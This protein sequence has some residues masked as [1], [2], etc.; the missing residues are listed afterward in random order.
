MKEIL[1]WDLRLALHRFAVEQQQQALEFY[2]SDQLRYAVL[3]PHA[4]KGSLPEPK[5]PPILDWTL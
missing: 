2:L 5:R 1:T 3:A 4:K